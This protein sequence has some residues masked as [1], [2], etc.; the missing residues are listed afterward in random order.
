MEVRPG[1]T[2]PRV[3]LRYLKKNFFL[4]TFEEKR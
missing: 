1:S 4:V 3:R 2:H